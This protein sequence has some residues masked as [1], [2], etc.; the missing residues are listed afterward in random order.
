MSGTLAISTTSRRELSSGFPPPPCKA[1][2]RGKFP[3]FWQKNFLFSFFVWLRTYQHPC[4][5]TSGTRSFSVVGSSTARSCQISFLVPCYITIMLLTTST[6]LDIQLNTRFFLFCFMSPFRIKLCSG[7]YSGGS[8]WQKFT[9]QKRTYIFTCR[10]NKD[11]HFPLVFRRHN[12]VTFIWS[13]LHL[14]LEMEQFFHFSWCI[15]F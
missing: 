11:C 5:C 13:T 10:G 3:P 2:G 8:Q 4:T 15:I 9:A 1:R 12:S 6:I 14:T 7:K